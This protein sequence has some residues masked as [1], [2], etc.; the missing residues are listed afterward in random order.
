MDCGGDPVGG[1][2][3]TGRK[4]SRWTAVQ[5]AAYGHLRGALIMGVGHMQASVAAAARRMW[6]ATVDSTATSRGV[7]GEPG[8]PADINKALGYR[9]KP[10]HCK[11]RSA[12]RATEGVRESSFLAPRCQVRVDTCGTSRRRRREVGCRRAGG[13]LSSSW[14][15]QLTVLDL[16]AGFD[17]VRRGVGGWAWAFERQEG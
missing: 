4:D 8:R 7:R 16:G 6:V 1:T 14:L 12:A 5:N 17:L 2:F 11:E 9:K 3:F 10:P 15:C 13:R